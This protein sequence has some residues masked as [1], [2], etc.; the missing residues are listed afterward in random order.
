MTDFKYRVLD[1]ATGTAYADTAHLSSAL[2]LLDAL[3]PYHPQ[4]SIDE[5]VS[6]PSIRTP[7]VGDTVRVGSGS[8][9]GS[10]G[11]GQVGELLEIDSE[12]SSWPYRVRVNGDS[13]GAWF[14]SVEPG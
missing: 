4:V 10:H 11:P 2:T 12:D 9:G 14:T 3:R 1:R 7:I 5:I 6:T 8:A 13:Y